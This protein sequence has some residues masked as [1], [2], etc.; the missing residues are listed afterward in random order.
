MVNKKIGLMVLAVWLS[1]VGFATC[2][3][4]SA[5]IGK[6]GGPTTPGQPGQPA[7]NLQAKAD[8]ELTN[9]WVNG[10]CHPRIQVTNKGE[11]VFNGGRPCTLNY[12]VDGNLSA[13]ISGCTGGKTLNPGESYTF[14]FGA[15]FV[16]GPGTHTLKA[17][18]DVGNK[19]MEANEE[20]NIKEVT[21]TCGGKTFP[22]QP[23]QKK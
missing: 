11:M 2:F 23:R 16:P 6:P 12:Y 14:E 13:P 1:V 8:L 10:Q 5:E 3:E 19:I 15:S 21:V 9:I 7:V 17:E 4:V 20:N 22:K 18:V